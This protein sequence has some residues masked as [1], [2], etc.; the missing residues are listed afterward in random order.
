MKR[1]F[2][3]LSSVRLLRLQM[4]GEISPDRLSPRRS[5]EV[6]E[7]REVEGAREQLIP[8]QLQGEEEELDQVERELLGSTM[9]ALKES[10]M[11]ASEEEVEAKVTRTSCRVTEK[12]NGNVPVEAIVGGGGGGSSIGASFA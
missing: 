10:R 5:T 6:T 7:R 9:E 1:L 12:N 4:E 2:A 3:R 11:S 8:A